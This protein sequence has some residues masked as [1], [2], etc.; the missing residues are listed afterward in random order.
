VKCL[1]GRQ[2]VCI[3][4]FC[5]HLF[6]VVKYINGL[7]DLVSYFETLSKFSFVTH[8]VLVAENFVICVCQ[9]AQCIFLLHIVLFHNRKILL[10]LISIFFSNNNNDNNNQR[11]SFV[12]CFHT[13]TYY[14]YWNP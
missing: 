10:N 1:L 13:Q 5:C 14:E 8:G 2:A 12:F 11:T 3:C 9:C 4:H 6:E 7:N